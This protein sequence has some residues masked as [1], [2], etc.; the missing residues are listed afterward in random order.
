M[1]IELKCDVL[2]MTN[3]RTNAAELNLGPNKFN[4]G[5]LQPNSKTPNLELNL[6]NLV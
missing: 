1:K 2:D 4:L 3:A 6:S 5:Q